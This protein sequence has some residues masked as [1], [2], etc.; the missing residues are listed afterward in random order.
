MAHSERA[1]AP[2]NPPLLTVSVPIGLQ[3]G[4]NAGSIR[5]LSQA[6]N[7]SSEVVGL[8]VPE[9]KTLALVGGDVRLDG[10]FLTAVGG[11]VELGGLYCKNF[12]TRYI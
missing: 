6:T 5:N 10:G 8:Q 2:Q 7:S 1:T 9:G 12:C 11:H 3:F 4:G